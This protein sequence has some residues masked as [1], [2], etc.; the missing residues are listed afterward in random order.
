M[1]ANSPVTFAQFHQTGDTLKNLFDYVDGGVGGSAQF[2]T[3][4][5]NQFGQPTAS[6]PVLFNFL[7]GAGLS[8]LLPTADHGSL[9]G[10][11]N[12]A[13]Q[14]RLTLTAATTQPVTVENFGSVSVAN[15]EFLGDGVNT[16]SITL[17]QTVFEQGTNLLTMTFTGGFLG[18][19]AGLTPQLSGNSNL[20]DTVVYTSDFLDFS[21]VSQAN[22]SLTYSSWTPADN[23]GLEVDSADNYF[24]SATSNGTGTFD[25]TVIPEPNAWMLTI[26]VLAGFLPARR[27]GAA[28]GGEKV[29]FFI[30]EH[31]T[32]RL[33]S[34]ALGKMQSYPSRD[35]GPRARTICRDCVVGDGGAVWATASR[36]WRRQMATTV[37]A[38]RSGLIPVLLSALALAG[39]ATKAQ[40]GPITFAQFHQVDGDPNSVFE[41]IDGGPQGI[42]QFITRNG[43]F[44]TIPVTFSYLNISEVTPLLLPSFGGTLPSDLTGTLQATLKLTSATTQPVVQ[45]F[46]GAFGSQEF[47]DPP[48]DTVNTL[49]ITLDTPAAEGNNGRTNLL[50]MTFTGGLLGAFGGLTPQ[51]SG[52]TNLGD[53]ITYTSDFLNFA[54]AAQEN[55]SLTYTS[56]TTLSD[57][58]GLELSQTP[59]DNYY[60]TATAQGAGTFDVTI[61][62]PS[63][64]TLVLLGGSGLLLA[65][66]RRLMGAA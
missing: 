42:A 26:L 54:L 33:A 58:N 56:W 45:G 34:N 59:N 32:A 30:G 1:G 6:I 13:L 37:R 20:G 24:N 10:D 44:S 52:N 43:D 53:S 4:G 25:V 40:A 47:I 11:L 51:L 57:G 60:A 8:G 63:G 19:E 39:L 2:I 46:G 12:G 29:F 38:R 15:Q 48:A 21:K 5:I 61:P 14:A 27:R 17:N 50:S 22:Y 16:L 49:S 41:Y 65:R 62:E 9:P 3:E 64:I 66:R 18:A 31:K 36:L 55:Y 28:A 7:P 35:A 23:G